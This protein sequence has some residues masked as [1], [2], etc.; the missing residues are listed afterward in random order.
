MT[1]YDG[2]EW[3]AEAKVFVTLDG[4][5]WI[6][7]QLSFFIYSSKV[8]VT[9]LTPKISSVNGGIELCV[10]TNA[11]NKTLSYFKNVCVGFQ[12]VSPLGEDIDP[13]ASDNESV[14]SQKNKGLN[15]L[16]LTI[17]DPE[18]EKSNWVCLD[19]EIKLNKISLTI[20]PASFLWAQR[21]NVPDP[22]SNE[23]KNSEKETL[24]YNIDVSLNSQQ[25]LGTPSS[26]RYYDLSV[27]KIEPNNS[28][29]GGSTC[30]T[31]M[32]IGFID[33]V[34]KKIK[35]QNSFGERLIDV[36]W[37]KEKR[38][39][40]FYTPPISWLCGNNEDPE[41]EEKLRNEKVTIWL[42]VSGLEW[43]KV[44]EYF[45]YEPTIEEI[46]P[47]PDFTDKVHHGE[48]A[49]AN[50]QN[51]EPYVD[52]LIGVP[53]KEIDKKK[54]EIEK[55]HKDGLTEIEEVFRKPGQALYIHGK[56]FLKVD[57]IQARC[58]YQQEGVQDSLSYPCEN[59]VFKNEEKLGIIVPEIE[60]PPAG[61]IDITIQLS[62]NSG[63]QFSGSHKIKY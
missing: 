3:P 36:K 25:F 5:R 52:P 33:S 51:E 39:F 1:V 28:A 31:I 57:T 55:H 58:T 16:D 41:I 12:A 60:G 6:D 23:D 30:I 40:F 26:F 4:E 11:D 14:S 10:E 44:G 13:E 46:L 24:F 47:G 35:L 20:P 19:G 18:L 38:H 7:C 29:I 27:E 2:M 48:A 63:Q 49:L 54:I 8:R 56:D 15:P 42:T 53:E 62:F 45:Y 43:F 32:G 17:G 21:P 50:W 9:G 61:V 59:A 34:A 22:L 37:D